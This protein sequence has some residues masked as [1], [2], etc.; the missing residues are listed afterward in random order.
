[1]SNNKY[2]LHPYFTP[3][4]Y[5]MYEY[6]P[7]PCP[8]SKNWSVLDQALSVSIPR[9]YHNIMNSEQCSDQLKARAEN[10]YTDFISGRGK[11]VLLTYN[12]MDADNKK[13][14][15]IAATEGFEKAAEFMLSSCGSYAE[16]RSKYG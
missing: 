11:D 13:A 15:D 2:H 6:L 4:G 14:A 16:M 9:L 3:D 7:Y 1:M 8:D 5:I 12:K 10:L